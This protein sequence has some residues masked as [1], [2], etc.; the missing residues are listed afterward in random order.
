[1]CTEPKNIDTSSKVN[2]EELAILEDESQGVHAYFNLL[3]DIIVD[4]KPS[5]SDSY[6]L[7]DCIHR[8]LVDILLNSRIH[9]DKCKLDASKSSNVFTFDSI[10]D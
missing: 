9:S 3:L 8:I 6:L 4:D 1:M 7:F 5:N 10:I 2:G